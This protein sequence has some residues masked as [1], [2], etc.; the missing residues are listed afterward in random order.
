MLQI[1]GDVLM[2]KHILFFATIM[3]LLMIYALDAVII[4]AQIYSKKDTDG[5]NH[6]V[7]CYSDFHLYKNTVKEKKFNV[8]AIEQK[9]YFLKKLTEKPDLSKTAVIVEDRRADF[10]LKFDDNHRYYL[11]NQPNDPL[12]FLDISRA[13]QKLAISVHNVNIDGL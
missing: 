4:K 1:E 7:I 10:D 5:K 2:G 3:H 6:Y 11:K 12:N 13:L 9:K 8:Q